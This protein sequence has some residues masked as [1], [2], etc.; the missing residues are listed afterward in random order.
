MLECTGFLSQTY[1]MAK[2]TFFLLHFI[3]SRTGNK[4]QVELQ[5]TPMHTYNM[6]Q[7]QCWGFFAFFFYGGQ[8]RKNQ[9][10]GMSHQSAGISLGAN[11]KQSMRFGEQR[12]PWVQLSQCPSGKTAGE[13]RKCWGFRAI[14]IKTWNGQ[15]FQRS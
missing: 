1:L 14:L 6:R 12:L 5:V 3:S 10:R 11:A 4:S 13:E 7:F 2:A 15:V 8:K 9:N